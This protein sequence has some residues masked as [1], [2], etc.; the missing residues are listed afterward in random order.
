M[1]LLWITSFYQE[2]EID[3]SVLDILEHVIAWSIYEGACGWRKLRADAH[4][5]RKHIET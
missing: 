1:E 2:V 3:E 4:G 5:K